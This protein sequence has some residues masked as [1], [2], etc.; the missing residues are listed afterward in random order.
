MYFTKIKWM[1]EDMDEKQWR[2]KQDEKIL[3]FLKRKKEKDD[4]KYRLS[5]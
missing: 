1:V 3:E 4:K 2:D 5:D